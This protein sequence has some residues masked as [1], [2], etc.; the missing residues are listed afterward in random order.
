MVSILDL[1]KFLPCGKD[2][3]IKIES[4]CRQQIQCNRNTVIVCNRVHNVVGIGENAD[5]YMIKMLLTSILSY[6]HKVKMQVTSI[7]SYPQT[8]IMLVTSIVSY[9]HKV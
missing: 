7:F 2:R 6:S 8:V 3:L 5:S 9:S 4:V 1:S